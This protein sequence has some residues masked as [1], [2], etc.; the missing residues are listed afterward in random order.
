MT[1]A[2]FYNSSRDTMFPAM[3]FKNA[4]KQPLKSKLDLFKTK[5]CPSLTEV[6]TIDYL[7]GACTRGDKCVFAHKEDEL[8]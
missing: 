4:K 8:R 5:M 2:G 3:N 6:A 7:K 1:T